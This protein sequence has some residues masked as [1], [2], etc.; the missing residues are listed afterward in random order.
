MIASPACRC[1][2]SSAVWPKHSHWTNTLKRAP[3]WLLS[4]IRTVKEAESPPLS[5]LLMTGSRS[6]VPV[7]TTWFTSTRLLLQ[8]HCRTFGLLQCDRGTARCHHKVFGVARHR[9]AFHDHL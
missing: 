2:A 1:S 9:V 8:C 3:D 4:S 5:A 7:I 6:M